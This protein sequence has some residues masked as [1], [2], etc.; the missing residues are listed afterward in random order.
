[1][2]RFFNIAGPCIATDHYLLPAIE[3]LPEVM[4]NI[5]KKLF[6]VIH[7]ARQSGKTTLLKHLEYELN[8]D[9]KYIAM[10]VSLEAVQELKDVKD[11][12]PAILKNIRAAMIFHPELKDYHFLENIDLTDYSNSLRLALSFLCQKLSKPLVIFFD[13]ADCLSEGTL[14]TFLRQIREGYIN[15]NSIPF[16]HSLALVGMRNIRDFR[17]QYVE[18][19]TLGSASPFNIV[20]KEMTLINFTKDEIDTLYQQHVEETKQPVEPDAIEKISYYTSGQP[21]L[22]N[23]IGWEITQEILKED[24]TVPITAELVKQAAENIIIKRQ[25]HIDS[26][27]ERL[28]E[29]RV[30]RIIEPVILGNVAKMDRDTDDY[31]Y[32]MDLGIIVNE[33]GIIKPANRIYREVI[34]RALN[35][36]SQEDLPVS[37]I[38]KWVKGKDVQVTELLKDFQQFWREN[39][40]IWTKN[41]QY[42][43][44]APHLVLQAF[45]QRVINGGGQIIREYAAGTRRFD[46]CVVFQ[47]NKYPIELKLHYGEKTL[48]DGLTQLSEYMDTV[49]EQE[50]WLIIFDRRKEKTWDEKIF[51]TTEI[52]NN[53]TIHV[54]GA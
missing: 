42:Q 30:Q 8:K 54:V 43:E 21:W 3:R 17:Y 13:E 51:W 45:L 12:I 36:N 11:G 39:S 53:K 10:Y 44:A 6:F 5:N 23:A 26:L 46:L 29:P 49:G 7:A 35:F 22:V 33:K 4:N 48:P 52:F 14:V 41:Y 27:L 37:Y 25:T 34:V 47:E 1:M 15:R 31:R 28:K 32:C 40:E 9:G 24:F 2:N 50:G 20:T 18:G 38:N 19:K 16:V